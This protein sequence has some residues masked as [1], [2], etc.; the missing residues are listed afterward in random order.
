MPIT[1]NTT[2]SRT[3]ADETTPVV[4]LPASTR[5]GSINRS[6]AH[7]LAARITEDGST[8]AVI[9]LRDHPLPLYDADL[10]AIG[11]TPPEAHALAEHLGRAA[12]LVIVS[13]EYNGSFSPLL[14][15]TIDWISRVDKSALTH[16]T[17]LVAAASPGRG[18]GAN[19]AEMVRTWMANMGVRV[20]EHSLTIGSVDEATTILDDVDE[21]ELDRFIAQA[22]RRP[23]M[24]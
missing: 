19:G 22:V 24:V 18:G 23:A 15:N 3:T 14:K 12:V 2:T 20:A 11:G 8:C 4:I 9:D 17:V 13:P 16:L 6:L 7:E 1:S 10:E 5:T 21:R